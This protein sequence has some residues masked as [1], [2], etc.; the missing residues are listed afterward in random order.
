MKKGGANYGKIEDGATVPILRIL[1]Y[2]GKSHFL[3]V[4]DVG[5]FMGRHKAHL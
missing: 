2:I 5:A 4:G 3:A 1:E